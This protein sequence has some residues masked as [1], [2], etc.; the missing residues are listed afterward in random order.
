MNRHIY[1]ID[2]LFAKS[3]LIDVFPQCLPSFIWSWSCCQC[4]GCRAQCIIHWFI[5]FL[6]MRRGIGYFSILIIF[7]CH[8]PLNFRS[9]DHNSDLMTHS[10]ATLPRDITICLLMKVFVSL[11]NDFQQHVGCDV[12]KWWHYG[13]RG[14]AFYETFHILT[15][16]VLIAGPV[17]SIKLIMV[18]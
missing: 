3:T 12:T 6:S 9:S 8:W 5:F 15:S 2:F 1:C 14:G 13:Y 18:V 11:W 4:F 10:W 7:P 17:F 16:S